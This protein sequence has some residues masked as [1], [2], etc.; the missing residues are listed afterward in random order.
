MPCAS[1]APSFVPTFQEAHQASHRKRSPRKKAKSHIGLPWIDAMRDVSSDVLNAHNSDDPSRAVAADLSPVHARA[2]CTTHPRIGASSNGAAKVSGKG[3]ANGTNAVEDIARIYHE[4]KKSAP[5]SKAAHAGK[6]SQAGHMH[7]SG[8]DGL[9]ENSTL[10]P[11]LKDLG[12]TQLLECIGEGPMIPDHPGDDAMTNPA[13][14]SKDLP[15]ASPHSVASGRVGSARCT[16]KLRNN[17]ADRR[18]KDSKIN[19][20]S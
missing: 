15:L 16:Q 8:N 2:A 20:R 4:I 5:S 18:I 13:G 10:P 17:S 11:Y 1:V 14:H 12:W 7:S 9:S 3:G 6:P 19:V